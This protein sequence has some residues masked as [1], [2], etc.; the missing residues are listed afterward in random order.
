MNTGDP[1]G[2]VGRTGNVEGKTH[3]HFQMKDADGTVECP[4]ITPGPDTFEGLIAQ[5]WARWSQTE[6]DTLRDEYEQRLEGEQNPP[7]PPPPPI[8]Y[9]ACAFDSSSPNVNDWT[10]RCHLTDSDYTPGFLTS[11]REGFSCDTYG[12]TCEF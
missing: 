5:P 2:R 4:L 6:I 1:I 12:V 7:P 11:P 10:W 9:V 8:K 3:L